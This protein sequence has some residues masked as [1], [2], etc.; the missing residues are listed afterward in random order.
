MI[1]RTNT[2][3]AL[4]T[5]LSDL[6]GAHTA[7]ALGDFG[8]LTVDDLMHHL[9]RRYLSGTQTTDLSEV[10]AGEHVAVVARVGKPNIHLGKDRDKGRLE[11]ALTDGRTRLTATFFGKVHLLNY[12]EH[13]L[14]TGVKG[15]FVGKVGVF[16]HQLQMSHPDFVMLDEHGAIVARGDDKHKTMARQV[17]RSGLVGIYPASAKIPTWTVSECANIVLDALIGLPDT[18][19]A[20]VVAVERLP[21]LIDAFAAI[22]RPDDLAGVEAATSRLKF[23]EAL[24]LQVT[25]A[26]RRAARASQP[27]P[28]IDWRDDGLLAAFDARLPFKLTPGQVEVTAEIA[29]DMGQSHPM[30]RLLQGEVGAGKTVV[31]LRAMLA[32]VDAGHQGVLLAPTEVLATQHAGTIDALMG[33]LVT[34]GTLGAPPISTR[35]VTLTGS[36]SAIA[37]RHALDAIANGEAGLVVGTHALLYGAKF[38]SLGLIVIDEQHRFGVEQRAVLS[39]GEQRPHVLVMTATPIPRSVAMTVFGDL[40]VSTLNDLPVGRRE[41]ATTVVA[42]RAHP[43]WLAR[44]WERVHEEVDGGRQVFVVCPRINLK[45]KDVWIE[46]SGTASAAAVELHRQL[47]NGPLAGMRV[48]LLHGQLPN[49]QKDEAM[50]DF[51]AHE[52]DVLVCTTIIEVGVDVPNASMMVVMDADRFGVSQLHQLRGRIGRG[53]EDAVCLLVTQADTDSRAAER[54]RTV[55]STNDGFK[56]AEYD[57]AARREGDVLG[58]EQSGSRSTLR[59]LRALDDTEL[60]HHAGDIAERLVAADPECADPRLADLVARVEDQSDWLDRS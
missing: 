46:L 47:L 35:L 50:A 24:A 51:V 57:L 20:D 15:I 11:A 60:I 33:D 48:G 49:A 8:L 37:R 10:R 31:A 32:A 17:T 59:L 25:M 58:A 43:T 6:L 13:T 5:P 23:E 1:W 19:P 39:S 22:H 55:A 2:A 7:K 40:K 52:I 28:A 34:A 36:M 44:V 18:L 38:A 41:V 42:L 54:L 3:A 30:Q 53:G 4:D 16:N 21:T 14:Q 26:Y 56:L 9:P 12:W 29:A 27:A 45:D